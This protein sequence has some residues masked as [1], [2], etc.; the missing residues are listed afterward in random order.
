MSKTQKLK[1]LKKNAGAAQLFYKDGSPYW[2]KEYNAISER[3]MHNHGNVYY[4]YGHSERLLMR[5]MLNDLIE[6]NET[7]INKPP[8]PSDLSNSTDEKEK[9]YEILSKLKDKATEYMKYLERRGLI[10]EIW[11]ERYPCKFW[12]G[13]GGD[14]NDFIKNINVL[15]EASF[16]I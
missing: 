10:V 13:D 6:D 15:K 4:S 1:A 11:S 5:N 7:T 8:K 16:V 12:Y 3:L 14:C 9:E 2:E